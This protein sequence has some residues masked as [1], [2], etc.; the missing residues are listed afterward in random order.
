VRLARYAPRRM[1]VLGSRNSERGWRLKLFGS[2]YCQAV[3]GP[4][5]PWTADSARTAEALA[6]LGR[7]D[8]AAALRRR[9]RIEQDNLPSR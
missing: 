1:M 7:I 2:V 6:V 3:L 9:H 5:S 4:P 8:E